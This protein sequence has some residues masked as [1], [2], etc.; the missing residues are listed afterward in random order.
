[1]DHAQGNARQDAAQLR[2]A[3]STRGHGAAGTGYLVDVESA[4]AC[5]LH[6]LDGTRLIAAGKTGQVPSRFSKQPDRS[7]GIFLRRR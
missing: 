4:Q 7:L 1:M 6:G 3:D 2:L 5:R